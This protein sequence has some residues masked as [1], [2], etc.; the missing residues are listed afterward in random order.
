VITAVTTILKYEG[1]VLFVGVKMPAKGF[2]SLSL[3]KD[4]LDKLSRYADKNGVKTPQLLYEIAERLEEDIDLFTILKA[5]E[6][7]RLFKLQEV[8]KAEYLR[9][10][11]VKV[12]LWLQHLE[13]EIKSVL[14]STTEIFRSA[15][16]NF[17]TLDLQSLQEPISLLNYE[18]RKLEKILD[19]AYPGGWLYPRPSI[20]SPAFFLFIKPPD[21][22]SPFIKVL[23]EGFAATENI[24][25][26]TTN[27]YIEA[28][29]N[30]VKDSLN[31]T[32]ED[33]SQIRELL[34]KIDRYLPEIYESING[35][36]KKVEDQLNRVIAEK[37]SD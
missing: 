31:H 30:A 29:K 14:A 19:E 28:L 5:I 8:V 37:I 21:L 33:I 10:V 17:S 4:A 34:V 1:S 2:A 25:Q 32:L 24:E 36:L 11:L 23:K 9:D 35:S 22:S 6:S 12:Y 15:L 16:A 27:Y 26:H 18:Q 20:P 3:K 7:A 13:I